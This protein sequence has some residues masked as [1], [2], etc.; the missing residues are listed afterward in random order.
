MI[1]RLALT[2]D[3]IAQF[4]GKLEGGI[5]D[6]LDGSLDGVDTLEFE[7]T[8]RQRR[9]CQRTLVTHFR[10]RMRILANGH[11]INAELMIINRSIAEARCGS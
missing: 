6:A 2:S 7:L 8:E 9:A 4:N 3:E 1:I 11:P 5:G 10:H